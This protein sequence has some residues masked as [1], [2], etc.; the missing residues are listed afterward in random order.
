MDYLRTEF[1]ANLD[2]EQEERSTI[3]ESGSSNSYDQ[4]QR[5]QCE[6]LSILRNGFA[7]VGS[8]A[9]L[10]SFQI[11]QEAVEMKH[12]GGEEELGRA[13]MDKSFLAATRHGS[14]RKV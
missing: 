13:G 1:Q 4:Q 8:R 2:S 5:D 10:K 9:K 3:S 11:F 14:T 6:L 12:G 7:T